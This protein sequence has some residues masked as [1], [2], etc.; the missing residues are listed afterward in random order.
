M[1]RTTPLD[2]TTQ[3]SI[4]SFIET[5]SIT[6]DANN[7]TKAHRVFTVTGR[8]MVEG[9]YG[10]V[11]TALGSAVT[12]AHWRTNDQTATLPISAV[13]GTT[14]SSFTVGS[15]LTRKSIVSVALS[16]DNASAAKVIDPVAATAPGFFM[17]FTVVQKT[18]GVQT[19]IEF[20]YTTTNAPTTGAITFYAI[21]KPL[22]PDGDLRAV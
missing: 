18:G 10:V 11:T 2:I 5:K 21:F 8:V 4:P 17:P 20:V 9:L 7:T 1:S 15:V 12:A 3:G 19:D 13:A 14:L 6:L 22:T 16:A